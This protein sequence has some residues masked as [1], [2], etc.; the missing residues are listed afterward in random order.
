M[1]ITLSA[2]PAPSVESLAHG[3]TRLLDDLHEQLAGEQLR[4]LE[5]MRLEP[6]DLLALGACGAAPGVPGDDPEALSRLER[7]GL[8]E[9]GAR[10]DAFRPTHE[11]R[12]LLDALH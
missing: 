11:G 7:R 12:A 6:A 3:L 4:A 8:V 2:P 1:A 5:R 10:R 9:A